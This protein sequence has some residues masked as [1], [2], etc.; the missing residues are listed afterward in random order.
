MGAMKAV[1]MDMSEDFENLTETSMQ[2]KGSGWEAQDGRFEG[3]VDYSMRY[4]YWFDNYANLM[5]ARTILQAFEQELAV[6]FDDNMGQ[7]VIISN[8]ETLTWSAR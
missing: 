6:L 4:I 8:Y 5:A 3:K 1:Y 7:W 2:F